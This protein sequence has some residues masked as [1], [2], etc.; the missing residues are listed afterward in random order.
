[1][2]QDPAYTTWG[3]PLRAYNASSDAFAAKLDS[4]G[5]LIWN[6]FLGG[7]GSDEGSAI[8]VDG[9]GNIY[10][11]GYSYATWGS[12]VRAYC[13]GCPDSDAFAAK[14]DSSGSLTWNTFLGGGQSDQGS[15]IAVDGDGNV[16]IAGSSYAAWGSPV[17]A[18]NASYDAFAA[19][20]DSSG[21]LTWNTFMGGNNYDYGEGIALDGSGNVY[22]AGYGRTTWGSP[23]QAYTSDYDAFAVK[24]NSSS[25]VLT[26]N[27]FMGGG[28][29]GDASN[30]I[31]ADGS[32]NIY[33]AGSS[34]AAWGSPVRAYSAS[35]DAFAAKLDSSGALTWNTF[36]GGSIYDYGEGIALDGSSNIYVTGRSNSPWG[37][38][39]REYSGNY[40]AFAAKICDLP[41]EPTPTPTPLPGDLNGDGSCNIMD[42]VDI[43]GHWAETGTPGWIRE[44][45]YEDGVIDIMDIVVVCNHW[46]G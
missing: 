31:A 40:D 22:V 33:V 25:G 30:G 41:A 34:S 3:S 11:A 6:T 10:V 4:S 39:V 20:L 17:R 9:S 35:Y 14:L 28:S 45:L 12:P 29:G 43:C 8:A 16:Y 36:L 23:V 2:W 18:Y 44:D 24:L 26:W 1:M 37:S 5:N 42:I 15:A 27:T 21:V 19:R 32:G 38:P 13:A 7:S 46:T